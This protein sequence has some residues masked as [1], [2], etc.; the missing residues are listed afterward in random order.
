MYNI[1]PFL[2][3]A[4][5]HL[6]PKELAKITYNGHSITIENQPSNEAI[7]MVMFE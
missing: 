7:S 2:S 5:A 1:I 4:D 3:G 6:V